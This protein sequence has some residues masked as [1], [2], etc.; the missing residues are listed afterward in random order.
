LFTFAGHLFDIF[1]SAG[2]EI[3]FV[4]VGHLCSCFKYLVGAILARCVTKGEP[5]I[6]VDFLAA[7]ADLA[8]L[9]AMVAE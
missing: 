3:I 9:L 7:I 4:S 1:Q 6:K 5:R 2:V 8:L